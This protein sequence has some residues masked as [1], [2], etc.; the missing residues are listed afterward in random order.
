MATVSS[1]MRLVWTGG[2]LGGAP[3]ET[4]MNETKK[5]TPGRLGLVCKNAWLLLQLS[6]H[7]DLKPQPSHPLTSVMSP[8]MADRMNSASLSSL[9]LLRLGS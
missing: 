9:T 7:L 5:H 6:P 2:R 3:H 8:V 1:W 4:L